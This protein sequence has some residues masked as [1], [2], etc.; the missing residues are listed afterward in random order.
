VVLPYS[1]T[2]EDIRKEKPQALILSGG[3]SCILDENAPRC[4][5]GVFELGVPILGHCYG[6]QL[7]AA[8]LGGERAPA[9]FG[10]TAG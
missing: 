5:R 4:D 7:T 8:V 6:M 2:L 10:N 3:P 9:R 1:A